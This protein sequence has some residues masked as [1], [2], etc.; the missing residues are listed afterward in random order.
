MT[1]SQSMRRGLVATSA[2]AV[3]TLALAACSGGETNPPA[4]DGGDNPV[5]LTVS[6]TQNE[7]TPNYYCGVELLK[8]RLEESG[9]GFTVDLYPASQL[10]PHADRFPMTQA[11]DI[12]IDLLGGSE[13][14]TT[15]API[16]AV[17]AAY[18]FDDVDH[19]FRW[20]DEGAAD[21]FADFHE[22]TGVQIVD[23]WFFGNRTFTTK[24]IEVRSPGDLSG[25]PIRFPNSP[26]FLANAAA[27]GVDSPVSVAVEELYS[28][29]QQGIAVGQEN[30]IP[31]THSSGYDEVLDTVVLNNHN[32][33]LQ[34]VIVSDRTFEKLN[35]EQT[36]VLESTIHEIRDENRICVEDET[37]EILDEYRSDSAYTVIEQGE[38]DLDAFIEKAEAYF[39]DYYDGETLAA[40]EGIRA[41]SD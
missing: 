27:L 32:V 7:Q 41:L 26:G 20:I 38:I 33:G 3:A 1:T 30:P 14:A 13:L 9:L 16:E 15:F 40:Y 19:A 5:T 23:G 4:G 24:G 39:A 35:E 11:G 12:D 17:D 8:E 21:L 34:F 31:A 28:A 25:V 22:A 10:G 37:D 18:A 2:I 6:L 36:A 29:L